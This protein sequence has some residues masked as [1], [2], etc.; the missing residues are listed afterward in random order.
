[1]MTMVVMIIIMIVIMM[2]MLIIIII[3]EEPLPD[4]G[5]EHYSKCHFYHVAGFKH[6]FKYHLT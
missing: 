2:M 3:D 5:P 6:S 1:M 4:N